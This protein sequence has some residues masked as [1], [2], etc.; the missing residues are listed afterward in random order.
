MLLPGFPSSSHVATATS[1]VVPSGTRISRCFVRRPWPRNDTVPV[2]SGVPVGEFAKTDSE[3]DGSRRRLRFFTTSFVAT[4]DPGVTG[5]SAGSRR[6][7]ETSCSGRTTSSEPSSPPS[8]SVSASKA[9]W[10]A[11]ESETRAAAARSIRIEVTSWVLCTCGGAT[12]R[13]R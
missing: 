7:H 8:S 9:G 1:D 10:L 2:Q 5:T 3:T 6:L 13:A 12:T 11:N 4:V